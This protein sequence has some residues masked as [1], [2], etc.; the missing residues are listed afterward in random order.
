MNPEN[1][2]DLAV[3]FVFRFFFGI[4]HGDMFKVVKD[5]ETYLAKARQVSTPK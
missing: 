2:S 3:F 1:G 5:P 4:S